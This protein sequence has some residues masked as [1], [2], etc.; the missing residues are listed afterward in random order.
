MSVGRSKATESHLR[1]WPADN[2]ALIGFLRRRK[3]GELPHGPEFAPIAGTVDSTRVRGSPGNPRY[4]W[5]VSSLAASQPGCRAGAPVTPGET[6]VDLACPPL[7][8]GRRCWRRLWGC[9]GF[10]LERVGK[11]GLSPRFALM[12]KDDGSRKDRPR[13]ALLPWLPGHLASWPHLSAKRTDQHRREFV[14][15][16]GTTG[17]SLV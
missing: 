15:E 4:S 1:H 9:S 14:T 10:F 11:S 8:A 16:Q 17:S 3:A 2:V 6:L 7:V 13:S 12:A 5:R